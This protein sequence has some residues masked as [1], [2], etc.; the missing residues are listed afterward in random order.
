MSTACVLVAVGQR[1]VMRRARVTQPTCRRVLQRVIDLES[2][3]IDAEPGKQALVIS[4]ASRPAAN[5]KSFRYH[6]L[7]A[8]ARASRRLVQLYEFVFD[9]KRERGRR[10]PYAAA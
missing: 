7:A 6:V 10:L 1:D 4:R 8:D 9:I 5:R 2:T 3:D